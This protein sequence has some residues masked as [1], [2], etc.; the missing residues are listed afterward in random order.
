MEKLLKVKPKIGIFLKEYPKPA[1]NHR[2]LKIELEDKKINKSTRIMRIRVKNIGKEVLHINSFLIGEFEISSN[3]INKVLENGWGQSSFSGYKPFGGYTKRNLFFL[4]RDQNPFSF[5]SH[6][7]YLEKSIVNEWYTQL[8]SKD[9]A[10]VIGAVTVKEQYSQVFLK[11]VGNKLIVR[12]T[13]Q[14]DGLPLK[15]GKEV[16][17]EKAA[18]VIGSIKNS[19]E[20]FG[21]LLK[22]LN[23]VTQIS[24]PPTGLCCAYY[25]QG[26]KVNEQY[27]L[28]QLKAIDRI[29]WKLGLEYIQIDAGYSL[30]GD[31]LN[32]KK[33]FP[34]GMEFIVREIKKRGM[35]AGIWIAPFVASPRSKLFKEHNEWF[36]KD[37][38]GNDFEARFTSPLDFLPSLQFRVLD[39]TRPEVQNYLTKVIKQFVDWGFELIKTDFTYPIGFFSNYSKPMT[40]VQVTRLGFETIRNAAGGGKT[41]I[42]SGITQLSPLVGLIDSVRVGFDTINPFVCGIP[43]VD[44]LVNHWMLNQNLRNCEARQFLNGKIWIND[45]DCLVCKPN[46][47][48]SKQMLDKHFQFISNYGG[49]RWIGDH[50]G[51]LSSNRYENYILN[52]F[53]FKHNDKSA[54]SV[55]IPTHNK[56]KFKRPS[57]L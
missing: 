43:I 46:S 13:S 20:K 49:S 3:G 28:E 1:L 42:M 26:N 39:V 18:I 55:V 32:T 17:S 35:K 45:A 57:I 4:K 34:K 21:S 41:H 9:H 47:G 40:R 48:L 44:R 22:E 37:N 36:L 12:V 23:E 15:P 51:K 24:K 7:G 6:Y 14:F 54:V 30:W 27:I 25:H 53:G 10:V 38:D 11:L 8:V 5:N 2:G 56:K 52:L 50:L 31:W 29:P 19:L 33:Q 16:Y